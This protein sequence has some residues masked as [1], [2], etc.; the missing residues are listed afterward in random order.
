MKSLY[1]IISIWFVISIFTLIISN[2]NYKE[3]LSRGGVHSAKSYKREG[4][5]KGTKVVKKSI[6]KGH[7]KGNIFSWPSAGKK[8]VT[9]TH[10]TLLYYDNSGNILPVKHGHKLT[11]HNESVFNDSGLLDALMLRPLINNA[12]EVMLKGKKNKKKHKGEKYHYTMPLPVDEN[13]KIIDITKNS[14]HLSATLWSNV[15]D[16]EAEGYLYPYN[17]TNR[18]NENAI[19][20]S[21][22]Y[23][24]QVHEKLKYSS[25]DDLRYFQGKK[26]THYFKKKNG[27]AKGSWHL[28]K[29]RKKN[30]EKQVTKDMCVYESVDSTKYTVVRDG[31][32]KTR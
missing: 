21:K 30:V 2:L 28:K 27:L 31:K 14:N 6:K 29:R 24:E 17:I 3:A 16:S 4:A 19:D 10:P 25:P 5:K 20:V 11:H 15:D 9:H 32:K 7:R 1:F 18:F 8:K 26:H 12:K 13:N 22:P 23:G